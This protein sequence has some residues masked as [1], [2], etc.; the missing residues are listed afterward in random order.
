MT[1]ADLIMNYK[2][3]FST[4]EGKAVFNDLAL[5]CGMFKISHVPG[6]SYSTA[7]NEG[8]RSV[9]VYIVGRL[10]MDHKDVERVYKENL[11]YQMEENYA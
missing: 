2:K 11:A 3:V 7:Y 5:T 6:D 10:G 1:E 8:Q 9:G 4:E